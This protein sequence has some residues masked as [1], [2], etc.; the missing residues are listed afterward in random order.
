M[1]YDDLVEPISPD[2]PCGEDLL[3]T[4]DGDFLAYYYDAEAKMPAR[5]VDIGSGERFD[6][7]NIDLKAET[8]SI[9][10]LLKRTR[11]L[12]L[13]ALEARFNA[14]AG[15]VKGFAESVNAMANLLEQHWEDVHPVVGD[16]PFER[17]S[18]IEFLDTRATVIAPLE[19]VTIINDRRAGPINF[20]QSMVAA[21]DVEARE[22][23]PNHDTSMLASVLGS[24]DNASE[25]EEA[26]ERFTLARDAMDRM[27]A[28]CSANGGD[29][30]ISID[31]VREK[32]DA[33]VQFIGSARSDLAGEETAAEATDGEEGSEDGEVPAG[34]ETGTVSITV[35]TGPVQSHAHAKALLTAVETYFLINEPSAPSLVLVS[36]AK[37]LVGRPLV[38]AMDLLLP[39]SAEQALIEMDTE[40]GFKIPMHRMRTLS[41]NAMYN[42]PGLDE[43]DL[44]EIPEIVAREQAISELKQIES[45]FQAKE[46]ASPIP[47]LIFKARSFMNRDFQSLVR[48]LIPPPKE[49][50]NW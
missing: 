32:L 22:G 45:F 31:K 6:P 20:R 48:D 40:S 27:T 36:Q 15:R 42:A 13:L 50:G 17:Q 35:T 18:A 38:E 39:D 12:R 2:L 30:V 24:P 14:L 25:V 37:D 19:Y 5:Y 33:I 9:E 16:N 44:P 46:P 10:G 49:D 26:F 8:K 11:D 7:M 28:A 29:V 3:D 23:E 4:G 34:G 1:R 21:G 41:E 47:A 43:T